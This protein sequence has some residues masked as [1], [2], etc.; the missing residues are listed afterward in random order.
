M[1]SIK[2]KGL[3]YAFGLLASV[4]AAPKQL[5]ECCKACPNGFPLLKMVKTFALDTHCLFGLHPIK[6]LFEFKNEGNS[7][8]FQ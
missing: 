6:A 3:L 4:A 1:I 2:F 8:D 7:I 5:S